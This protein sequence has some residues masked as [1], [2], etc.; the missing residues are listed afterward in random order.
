MDILIL[1]LACVVILGAA[2]IQSR[3]ARTERRLARA[4]RKLD[5]L[6][7]HFGLRQEL[8]RRD[9]ITALLRE[10]KKIQAIKVYREATGADLVE[11]KEAVD[12]L[13]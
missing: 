2:G 9:E 3:I 10:G 6:L 7:D 5:L 12:R 13:G 1:F 11:A 8:P 4:E